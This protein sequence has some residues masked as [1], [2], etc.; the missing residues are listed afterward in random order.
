M[1]DRVAIVGGN[2]VGRDHF[3]FAI[4]D[5]GAPLPQDSFPFG[6]SLER[7]AALFYGVK[8]WRTEIHIEWTEAGPS[9]PVSYLGNATIVW[10]PIV[11]PE[12]D[13][14]PEPYEP[15][16]ES[17]L[18]FPRSTDWFWDSGDGYSPDGPTIVSEEFTGDPFQGFAININYDVN[19]HFYNDLFWQN[20]QIRVFDNVGNRASSFEPVLTRSVGN[21]T[22]LGNEIVPMFAENLGSGLGVTDCQ[23]VITAEDHWPYA[24]TQGDPVYDE[25]TGAILNDPFS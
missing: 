21:F 18:L 1:S 17:D 23:V 24:T 14:A 3:P 13:D 15:T 9:G 4:S 10:R 8:T 7:F 20:I 19:A 22:F 2:T 25:A 6:L 11:L 16:R 5:P 12:G